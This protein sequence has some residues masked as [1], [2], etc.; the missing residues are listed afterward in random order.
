[1]YQVYLTFTWS[2]SVSCGLKLRHTNITI[3]LNAIALDYNGDGRK[4]TGRDNDA[5]RCRYSV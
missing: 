4:Y 5:L 3:L 2:E 1:M